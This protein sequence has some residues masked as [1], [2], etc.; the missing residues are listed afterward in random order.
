MNN[1]KYRIS[2]SLGA[3][4]ERAKELADRTPLAGASAFIR[5]LIRRYGRQLV[6]DMNKRRADND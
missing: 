1:E 2:A 3:E 5:E 6:K 4:W